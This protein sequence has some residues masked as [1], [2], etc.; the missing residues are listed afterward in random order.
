MG[1]ASRRQRQEQQRGRRAQPQAALLAR[2]A[3]IA[4]STVVASFEENLG[5]AAGGRTTSADMTLWPRRRRRAIEAGISWPEWSWLPYQLAYNIVSH[6]LDPAAGVTSGDLEAVIATVVPV[7]NWLPGRIAVRYDPDILDTFKAASLD[8]KIP[9]QALYRQP[10]WGL[11]LDCP[12]L[13]TD[14]G[15]FTSL[16]PGQID[17]PDGDQPA[18]APDELILTFVLP[19]RHPQ[20]VRL[21]L[22]LGHSSIGDALAAQDRQPGLPG[23]LRDALHA[24]RAS[25]GELLGE[26]VERVLATVV[27]MLL[28]LCVDDPDIESRP[29]SIETPSITYNR[30]DTTVTVMEAGWRTGSALRAARARYAHSDSIA[31]GHHVTPHLRK[32]HWHSYWTG[33]LAAPEQRRLVLHYL[34]PIPVGTPPAEVAQ[35]T[36]VRSAD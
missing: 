5:L 27:S 8:A 1:K 21:S 24:T 10:A 17:T 16:D 32:A 18:K 26:P 22:W 15:V 36:V 6:D 29:L 7:L 35:L 34:P 28:Y 31:T 3:D 12:W 9:T 30:S 14:A 11:F 19:H 2:R 20:I 25:L 4:A 33:R 13:D 23:S